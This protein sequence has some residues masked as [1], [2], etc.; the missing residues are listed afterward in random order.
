MDLAEITNVGAFPVTGRLQGSFNLCTKHGDVRRQ[1]TF[2]LVDFHRHLL[3]E[4]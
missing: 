2:H 3:Y 1:R 4:N